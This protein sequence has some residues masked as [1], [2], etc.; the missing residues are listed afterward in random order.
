MERECTLPFQLKS[1][2][3][4]NTHTYTQTHTRDKIELPPLESVTSKYK[5]QSSVKTDVS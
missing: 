1:F 4:S 2:V 3:S 5:V